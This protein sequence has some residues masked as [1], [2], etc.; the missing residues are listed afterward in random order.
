MINA[1]W[2]LRTNHQTE[3]RDP[4]GEIV[5]GLVNRGDCN[6]IGRTTSAG[7]TR[8]PVMEGPGRDS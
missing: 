2:M 7:W 8:A 4:M 5:E 3:L 6:H 1:M